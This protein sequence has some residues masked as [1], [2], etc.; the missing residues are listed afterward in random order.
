MKAHDAYALACRLA[1]DWNLWGERASDADMDGI[2]P[3]ENTENSVVEHLCHELAHA[4]LLGI[5]PGPAL[6]NRVSA[7]I[8][9][10]EVLEPTAVD[11]NELETFSV[12]MDVLTSL[13]IKY[14][15]QVMAEA[16]EI[17]MHCN[18]DPR[19]MIDAVWNEFEHTPRRAAAVQTVLETLQRE[20]GCP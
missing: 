19:E 11:Q 20:G 10:M 4:A 1:R 3:F 8:R 15:R 17:Q 16:A 6:A 7:A 12:V 13:G 2:V 18:E 5:A 9:V 14:D